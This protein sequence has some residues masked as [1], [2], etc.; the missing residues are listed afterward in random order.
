[1]EGRIGVGRGIKEGRVDN[2]LGKGVSE[3]PG[4]FA[5]LLFEKDTCNKIAT[6]T[7]CDK[8]NGGGKV[9]LAVGITKFLMDQI[10]NPTPPRPPNQ[11]NNYFL[12]YLCQFCFEHTIFTVSFIITFYI[13]VFDY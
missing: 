13:C 8:A 9:R 2:P 3:A 10:Q 11:Q 6:M 5:S 12:L 1:M 7:K 4:T